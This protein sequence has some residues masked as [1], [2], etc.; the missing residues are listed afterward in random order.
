V[1]TSAT[2]G[3]GLD[4]LLAAIEERISGSDV[5]RTIT[6]KPHEGE[7]LAWLY[8]HAEVLEREDGENGI[9]LTLRLP[10]PQKGRAE[11][12]FGKRLIHCP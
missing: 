2:T 9:T 12:R 4:D 8:R 6:L 11:Q 7:E 1:I 10:H 3:E 5:I